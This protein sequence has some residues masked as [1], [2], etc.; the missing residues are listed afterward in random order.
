MDATVK[1]A[2]LKSSQTMVLNPKP[3]SP[4]VTPRSGALRR[5]H[6]SE[7]LSS[8][9]VTTEYEELEPP[10]APFAG[11]QVSAHHPSSIS[12]SPT[13]RKS[14]HSR[15]L[16]FDAPRIFSRSQVHLPASTSTLDLTAPNKQT[17]EKF[18]ATKNITPT[19]FFSI[20][21]GTSSTQL[22]VEDIKKLRLLL[23]NE[24]ARQVYSSSSSFHN[25]LNFNVAGRKNSF[26]S[27]GTQPS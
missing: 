17:K 1:A 9:R 19:K 22:D 21:S 12:G 23:R 13:P 14:S 3:V 26:R 27:V 8:P 6:S 10:Q 5:A 18:T 20:L 16:S 7:T 15:G 25:K 24:S 11:G 4:P 2:M